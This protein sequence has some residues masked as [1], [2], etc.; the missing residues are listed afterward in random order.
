[1]KLRKLL[2]LLLL[3][4]AAFILSACGKQGIQGETGDAGLKGE[5]GAPGAKG[6]TGE[7]G[8]PGAKGEDG[9]D[10]LGIQFS[11]G[12]EGITWK[13]IGESSWNDGFAYADLFKFLETDKVAF[14]Y[15]VDPA[16]S[17]DEGAPLIAH[18]N[19]LV[20][21]QT[22]FKTVGAAMTAIAA[23][24]GEKGYEGA[25][26][27]LEKGT[28]SD[29]FT[30]SVKDL[31][32][33]GPN[34]NV[35]AG[36]ETARKDEADITGKITIADT[37]TNVR[38]NGLK[39]TKGGQVTGANVTGLVFIYNLLDASNIDGI[40]RVTTMA[41]DLTVCY[42][43]SETY[44]GYRFV[45][46]QSANG[47][48]VSCNVI[49][50]ETAGNKY[51]FINAQG[52]IKGKVRIIGNTYEYSQQSFI[53][54]KG[55]GVIDAEIA[56]NTVVGIFATVIDFRNMNEDGA[57]KFDIHNNYFDQSGCDWRPIR[58]RTAGYEE[59]KD[60]VVVNIYDNA[61]IDSFTDVDGTKTF[62]NNPSVGGG[63]TQIYTVGKNYYE[64]QGTAITTITAAN[65]ADHAV[66]EIGAPYASEDEIEE[67]EIP[68]DLVPLTKF[69]QALAELAAEF[70]ADLKTSTNRELSSIA[71]LDTNYMESS[72]M[73][74]FLGDAD[75]LA[76][77]GWLLSALATLSG[78]TEHD[79]TI[80]GFDAA[81]NKGF[82][83]ANINAFF[84]CSQ[85]K[86]TW[87]ETESM[88]F[89]DL[90]NVK[91]V[92]AEQPPLVDEELL[93]TL[94]AAFVADFNTAAGTEIGNA[95]QLDTDYLGSQKMDVMVTDAT[96]A[97]K[98]QWL[99]DALVELSGDN[100]K[101]ATADNMSSLRGFYLANISGFFT[102]TA[103]KDTWLETQ[104]MDF[105][106]AKN[107]AA[108][109]SAYEG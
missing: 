34:A 38:I 51:D 12:S 59:G 44:Q 95:G 74:T 94:A 22:A 71:N 39:F 80:E 23:A 14:D 17:L 42:N 50:A 102:Q 68:S 54:A 98:W 61:F 79:P 57:N 20:V 85:H 70:L 37:A 91:A 56:G 62:A 45:W 48:N 63:L 109:L 86:D 108:V 64:V 90:D 11:Y 93:A 84:T 69:E 104:G 3:L 28:Y 41:T 31:T 55:V 27:Y 49:K 66:G 30:V 88:D 106:N 32:I 6:P 16:L 15:Y 107:V 89:A 73:A 7:A 35:F 52:L 81:A 21:G 92:L 77:W 87:L 67:Y 4:S 75:M 60:S 53:Y 103:H 78:D 96:F 36:G 100:S 46:L 2:V 97:A 99:F 83:L 76:K 101:I 1:M 26:L 40:V 33:I 43:Y 24:A 47:L 72:E 105:T 9:A 19:E 82:F 18:G 8:N 5:T 13:Y 10:G 29:D 65:F 58:I 25:T